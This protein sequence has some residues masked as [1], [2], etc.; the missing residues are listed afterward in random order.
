VVSMI[1]MHARLTQSRPRA[2]A[3]PP[4]CCHR[5]AALHTRCSR[6]C[7]PEQGRDA[8]RLLARPARP[9]A[10]HP[11]AA[12]RPRRAP[13]AGARRAA[14]AAPALRAGCPAA[15]SPCRARRRSSASP[16]G[17]ALRWAPALRGRAHEAF[18]PGSVLVC[19]RGLRPACV[20]LERRQGGHALAGG[21]GGGGRSARARARCRAARGSARAAA[22]RPCVRGAAEARAARPTALP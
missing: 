7:T 21:R 14:A 10:A 18:A 20:L 12:R 3:R 9:A 15:C 5:S 8:R 11:P 6:R 17:C 1:S 13:A 16:R 4:P 19:G 22:A 2:L